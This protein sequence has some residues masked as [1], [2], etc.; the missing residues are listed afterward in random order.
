MIL[1]QDLFEA[2][3]TVT[4]LD[5]AIAFYRDA[6]GLRLAHVTSARQAGSVKAGNRTISPPCSADS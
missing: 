3:L 4:D 2:H 5:R 1:V 6:V